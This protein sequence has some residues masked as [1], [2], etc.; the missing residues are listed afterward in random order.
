MRTFTSS[1]I[2]NSSTH[3]QTYSFELLSIPLREDHCSILQSLLMTQTGKAVF[4]KLPRHQLQ[5]IKM[6]F[7]IAAVFGR[8]VLGSLFNDIGKVALCFW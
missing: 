4:R 5:E 3:L 8:D 7:S 6:A 1:T 2:P